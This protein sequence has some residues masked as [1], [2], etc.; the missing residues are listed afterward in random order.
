MVA[1]IARAL[2]AARTVIMANVLALSNVAKPIITAPDATS[3]SWVTAV[4]V[5]FRARAVDAAITAIIVYVVAI[6]ILANTILTAPDAT[7]ARGA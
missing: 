1:Y 3:A 2:D 6:C 7:P 5:A 4:V